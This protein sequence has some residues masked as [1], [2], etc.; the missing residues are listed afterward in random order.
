LLI[1]L[2]CTENF[3]TCK[4]GSVCCIKSLMHQMW[5]TVDYFAHVELC[6]IKTILCRAKLCPGHWTVLVILQ[7]WWYVAEC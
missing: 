2:Q 1:I 6:N 3:L 4:I 5:C 7:Y